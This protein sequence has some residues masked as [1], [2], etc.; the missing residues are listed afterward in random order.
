MPWRQ[1]AGSFLQS[2]PRCALPCEFCAFP[3]NLH[4]NPLWRPPSS[5]NTFICSIWSPIRMA[6][7]I[8]DWPSSSTTLSMFEP[9]QNSKIH[10][11]IPKFLGE[12]AAFGG[13]NIEPS[14]RSCFENAKFP[15]TINVDQFLEWLKKE[16]QSLVWLP[17]MH[18]LAS[19]EFAKHQAKCNACKMFPVGTKKYIKWWIFPS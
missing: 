10:L 17:V 9:I 19:S 15:P 2:C 3:I 14:V 11:K 4:I 18:R 13:S 16:P 1:N 8:N 6:L 7:T 12:A 5:L